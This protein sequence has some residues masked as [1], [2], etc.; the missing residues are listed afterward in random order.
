MSTKRGLLIIEHVLKRAISEDFN[1]ARTLTNRATT[2][3]QKILDARL[4]L[5]RLRQS[6]PHPRL[7]VPAATAT[8]ESQITTMQ[9]LDDELQT[10]NARVSSAKEDMR[11]A[12]AEVEKLRAERAEAEKAAT[13]G[14]GRVGEDDSRLIPLYDWCVFFDGLYLHDLIDT[15]G[16]GTR[17]RLRL[18]SHLHRCFHHTLSQRTSSA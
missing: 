1:R 4:A 3:S 10:L 9:E 14:A 2:L 7:T 5:T 11:S 18:T 12:K 13:A 15:V 16:V 8:L 6:H 17:H